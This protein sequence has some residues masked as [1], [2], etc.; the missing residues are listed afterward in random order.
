MYK[1]LSF[2][3][4]DFIY[5]SCL[6]GCMC[7]NTTFDLFSLFSIFTKATEGKVKDD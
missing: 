6:L 1:D 4:S 5:I 7:P 3:T 2:V